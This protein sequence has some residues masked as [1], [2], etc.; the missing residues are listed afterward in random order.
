MKQPLTLSSVIVGGN[1]RPAGKIRIGFVALTISPALMMTS[2][3][4]HAYTLNK[5][6]NNWQVSSWWLR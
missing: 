1:R 6:I 4:S 2:A 3:I 5:I